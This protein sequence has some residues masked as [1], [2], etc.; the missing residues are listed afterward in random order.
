MSLSVSLFPCTFGQSFLG[1]AGYEE[2]PGYEHQGEHQVHD[3]ER[4]PAN[5]NVVL[6]GGPNITAIL[7]CICLSEHVTCAYPDALPICGNI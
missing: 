3:L 1:L 2:D 4:E 6:Q 7:Y 5:I